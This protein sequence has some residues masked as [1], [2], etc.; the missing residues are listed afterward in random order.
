MRAA[1]SPF[2]EAN[3]INHNSSILENNTVR[4]PRYRLNSKPYAFMNNNVWKS[5]M[6]NIS[7][8]IETAQ[9]K[10]LEIDRRYNDMC[11]IICKEMD[12]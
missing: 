9:Y 7:D 4:Q 12:T 1:I 8:K 2:V 3:E 11:S 10:Q 6:A 5:A